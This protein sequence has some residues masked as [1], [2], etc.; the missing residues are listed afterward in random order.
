MT[1]R[2]DINLSLVLLMSFFLHTV[3]M[4]GI[5]IPNYYAM[6]QDQMNR[7]RT[8]KMFGGRD[9]IVN[10]NADR[11]PVIS[12]KTL[13]SD[14]DSSAR[15][16]LTKE[17]GDHWLNNSRDFAQKRGGKKSGNSSTVQ[18]KSSQ[19]PKRMLLNDE[20]ELVVEFMKLSEGGY[21]L[22]GDEGGEDFTKV[23]DR[24]T[25]S[26][27]N[28]IFYSNDGRFSFNTKRFRNFRYFKQMKD[29]IAA[30]WHP[31][32]M[33]KS[34]IGGYA[35]GYVKINAIPDQVVKLYFTMDRAGNVLDVVIVESLGNRQLDQS[36]VESIR[37]SKSFGPVPEDVKGQI[38]VIPFMFG[39]FIY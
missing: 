32:D 39:Y 20:S 31:P 26:K 8:R 37:W 34:V 2:S 9:I 6:L 27:N 19:I 14:E 4:L 22:F 10:I 33:A 24:N 23:P 25:F 1:R 35:P 29:K 5:V 11:Q 28:A 36:C 21:T 18:T 30:N 15:G 7:D 12:P 3:M 38:V 13:L 16:H 17:K